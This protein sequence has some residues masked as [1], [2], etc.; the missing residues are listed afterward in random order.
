M[1][2][3]LRYNLRYKRK[4]T[5][6]VLVLIGVILVAGVV[7]A[8]TVSTITTELNKP[9]AVSFDVAKIRGSIEDS[10][11]LVPSPTRI[12]LHD[13]LYDGET[14]DELERSDIEALL[15]AEGAEEPIA[16][17][18]VKLQ[19]PNYDFFVL[20]SVNDY[21]IIAVHPDSVT[22]KKDENFESIFK[23]YITYE[24]VQDG[25][26]GSLVVKLVTE[27]VDAL[28]EFMKNSP[29]IHNMSLITGNDG[30]VVDKK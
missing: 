17:S 9:S 10:R 20:N 15:W 26:N 1:F 13:V 3:K 28:V 5:M 12:D 23:D 21:A 11:V 18:S 30:I 25:E 29:D 22:T 8:F 2:D 7:A 24:Y 16:S 4:Q 19:N 14:I 6:S 27:D